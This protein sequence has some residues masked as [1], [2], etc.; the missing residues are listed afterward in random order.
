[1]ICPRCES[2]D[3]IIIDDSFDHD[4][5][6]GGTQIVRYPECNKC[7]YNDNDWECEE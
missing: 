5:A 6:G 3:V 2:T 1:M 4:W 7:G